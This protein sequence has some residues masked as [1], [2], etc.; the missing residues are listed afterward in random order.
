MSFLGNDF[1]ID[2]KSQNKGKLSFPNKKLGQEN[3]M[4]SKSTQPEDNCFNTPK[5]YIG[6]DKPASKIITNAQLELNF[7][8]MNFAKNEVNHNRNTLMNGVGSNLTATRPQYKGELIN[9][10][11]S[12]FNITG[13]NRDSTF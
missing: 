10:R 4:I 9:E 8:P 11:S 12:T 5:N 1:V 3:Y 6:T 2:P 13:Y 7:K